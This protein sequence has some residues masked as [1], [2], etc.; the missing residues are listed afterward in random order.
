MSV[1]EMSRR[2]RGKIAHGAFIERLRR[3]FSNFVLMESSLIWRPGEGNRV[4][5]GMAQAG[6]VQIRVSVC[7]YVCMYVSKIKK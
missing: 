4:L 7:M 5:I 2:F 3:I 6:K 1:S